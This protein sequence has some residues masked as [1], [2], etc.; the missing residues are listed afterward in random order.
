M[1]LKAPDLSQAQASV[2]AAS[3]RA[4]AYLSSWGSW[5]A[6]K[7]T[8]WRAS[9]TSSEEVVQQEKKVTEEEQPVVVSEIHK[10]T[11][12]TASEPEI[13]ESSRDGARR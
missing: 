2:Q 6:E 8:K 11:S 7:K 9:A 5:A 12:S 1:P 10:R 4:G 3:A 13:G